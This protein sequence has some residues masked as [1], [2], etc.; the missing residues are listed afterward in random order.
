M[1]KSD[2]GAPGA[3]VVLMGL[4]ASGK[5]TLG[6]LL[7]Q[8]LGREFVDLDD[9]TARLMHAH[10]P[11]EAIERDG[12][13]AFRTAESQALLSELK[14]HSRVIALGGGTPTAPGCAQLLREAQ[15]RG[16]CLVIYLRASVETLRARLA[17]AEHHNRPALTAQGVIDEVQSLFDARDGLYRDLAHSVVSVDGVSEAS[18]VTALEALASAG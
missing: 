3:D 10:G 15:D 18:L 4:R 7:A 2:M 5:S 14:G 11:G 8:R 1:G 13:D 6:A 12:I 9:V 17:G 16:L